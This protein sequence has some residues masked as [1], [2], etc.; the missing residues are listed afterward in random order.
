MKVAIIG[1]GLSGL[2]C[3]FE[4]K[5]HGIIPT[6]FEKKIYIGDHL[7]YTIVFLRIFDPFFET[8]IK[9]LNKNYGLK[10]K[11][12]NQLNKIT[13]LGPTKKTTIHGKLGFIFKKNRES[14]SLENQILKQ[15]DLPIIFDKYIHPKDFK[16]D[17]DAIVCAN[18]D[19]LFSN[20]LNNWHTTL[21]THS[22]IA[23]VIGDFNPNA[24]TMWLNTKYTKHV[25]AYMLPFSKDKAN[26][27]LTVENSS[28]DE[29]DYY[30]KKFLN[31]E[32]I[33]YHILETR[34]IEHTAG[35]VDTLKLDNIYF[36]GNSAGLLG[37]LLGFGAMN[38]IESG[39]LVG[40]AIAKN[41]DY[42]EMMTPILKNIAYL[43]R[44]RKKMNTFTNKDY[45][46]LISFL[47]LPLIKQY[48]YNNPFYKVLKKTSIQD[49]LSKK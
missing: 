45:D 5:K 10:I 27:T 41:L 7:D 26:L 11:P 49:H 38:A 19:N 34:D 17:F 42:N 31:L 25:Y 33:N 4:L 30:W 13:M 1:G 14:D 16:N 29:L 35:R 12:L 40:K 36:T 32:N 43:Y 24:L 46:R 44:F 6:V 3:A 15:L 37:N 39:I 2:S 23:T 48:I 28:Y 8:P 21:S 20:E 47:G 18:G 9:Y 22:R